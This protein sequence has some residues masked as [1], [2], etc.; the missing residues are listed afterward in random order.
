M[1][2][3]APPPQSPSPEDV[4]FVIPTPMV[5][6]PRRPSVLTTAAIALVVLAFLHALAGVVGLSVGGSS[7]AHEVLSTE[8]TGL[9]TAWAISFMIL[10]AVELAAGISIFRLWGWGRT[11]GFLLAVGEFLNGVR[12]LAGGQG[13]AALGVGISL[14]LLY[15]LATTG[16]VF[17]RARQ[18]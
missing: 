8:A 1:S 9:T 17:A 10:G 13:L 14:F 5:A 15:A 4:P 6:A 16:D 2:D 11:L 3:D 18:G 7:S 12:V